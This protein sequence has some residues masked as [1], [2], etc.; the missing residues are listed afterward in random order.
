[1]RFLFFTI[2]LTIMITAAIA[3]FTQQTR[4]DDLYAQGLEFNAHSQYDR[5]LDCFNRSLEIDSGSA[6][7][8][9]AKS[10]TLFNMRRFDD[11]IVSAD[12]ALEIDENYSD[13]WLI[14][15]EIFRAQGKTGDAEFCYGKAKENR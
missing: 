6:K 8:W 11:A 5:A 10:V 9:L 13:A 4:A 14:K 3:G 12:K 2:T 1:M 7:V 15:G